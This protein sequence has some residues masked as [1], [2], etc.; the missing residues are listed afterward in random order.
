MD[1]KI[2]SAYVKAVATAT[3]ETTIAEAAELMREHHVGALVVVDGANPAVPVGMVTDRDIAIEVVAAGLDPR[4]V[5]VGEIVQRPITTVTED[6]GWAE[7]VRLMS[8][9]GVRRLPVVDAGGGLIGIV[10]FDDILLQLAGPLVAMA[11]LAGRER[12]FEART[13][14]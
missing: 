1:K 12:H 14:A 10:S 3:G 5:K 6:A 4:T 11:D 7:T 13:R 8:I 2:G 9:N